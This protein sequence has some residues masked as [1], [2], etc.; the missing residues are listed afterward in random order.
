MNTLSTSLCSASRRFARALIALT[1]VFTVVLVASPALASPGPSNAQRGALAQSELVALLKAAPLPDGSRQ[2]SAAAAETIKP[3]SGEKKSVFPNNEVGATKFF[4]APSAQASLTWLATQHLEGHAPSLGTS[5]STHTE[6]YFL[7]PTSILLRPQVVYI[8]LAK[9]N[10]TLE[11][12]ITASVYWQSQKSP[13]ATVASGAT[14][15]A[16]KLNRG[17]NVKTDRTSSVTTDD[18]S[19]ISAIIAHIN[20]LSAASP[21]P[22]SCPLDVGASLTMSF[23]RGGATTPYAT[24]VADPGGCGTVTVNQ[25]DANHRRTSASDVAG[26]VLLAKFVATQLGLKNL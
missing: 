18:G 22:M 8:A 23:Y 6:I 13:L 17:L 4:V 2:I 15:L 26:G 9:A 10:G 7:S 24:V 5:G 16:A 19:L 12:S 3:F 11:F 20:A 14:T 1:A 21:L 25:Y